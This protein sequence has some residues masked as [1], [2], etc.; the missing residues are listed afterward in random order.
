MEIAQPENPTETGN[1]VREKRQA[2]RLSQKQLADLA[3]I[4]RQAICAVEAN[5][6]S[7]STSV[8]L[9]LAQA[10]RCRVEDLF[11]LKGGGE[12]VEGELIGPLPKELRKVRA[13]VSQVGDRVL[14][15]SL[16]G[17]GELA[18]LSTT[19]DGLIVE[20]GSDA[21][22]VKVQLFES[23]EALGR[24]ILVAGCD[25]AMFLAA[26]HLKQG[27]KDKLVPCLMG[28]STAI[29][30]LK[31][32]EVHVAGVHL[33]DER[34]GN[35]NLPYLERHLKGMECLV[36]TFAHWEEG[37]IV[38]PGN[39]KKIRGAA[40]LARSTVRI[41]NRESGSGARRLLDRE[42]EN[43]GIR[44]ASIKGYGDE[45][46]SHLEVG[47]RV[48]AGLA[49]A[50]VAIEAAASMCGLDFIALQ[51]ERYDLVI[52]KVH[53]DTLP[54]LRRLLDI[55]VGKTFRD[56]LDGLGG[57]DTREIGR[58]VDRATANDASNHL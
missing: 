39:P 44:P 25:P 4:T 29:G 8:A 12:V 9:K 30:A 42:L 51:R 5:Q 11:H 48:K 10:L 14:V 15:R 40:D 55:M 41:V 34:S 37:L 53:Y 50:G 35:W 26:E 23:R 58:V 49:D 52:P 36:V 3:G 6:Y 22:F 46:F 1:R 47:A 31:R 57:Y 54:G 27:A 56:E 38:R 16:S 2:R 20:R 43:C 19:A 18:S 7:P 24:N 45:V 13:Q 21:K 17:Q 33:V 32:R 28:S